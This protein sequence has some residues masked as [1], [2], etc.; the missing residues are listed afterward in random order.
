MNAVY[1]S[2]TE[3]RMGNERYTDGTKTSEFMKVWI[4]CHF[5]TEGF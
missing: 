3:M 5:F 4:H 2:K 1:R